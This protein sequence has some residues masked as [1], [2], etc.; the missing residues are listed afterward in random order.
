MK[1]LLDAITAICDRIAIA[2][3]E[4]SHLASRASAPEPP[5]RAASAPSVTVQASTFLDVSSADPDQLREILETMG[6]G[7]DTENESDGTCSV[8]GCTSEEPLTHITISGGPEVECLREL[9][10]SF[11]GYRHTKSL[12]R[13]RA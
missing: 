9:V 3:M 4:I 10:A 12:D 8:T 5:T 6:V 11:E 1:K 13:G 2:C 7:T